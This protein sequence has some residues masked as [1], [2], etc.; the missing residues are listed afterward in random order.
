MPKNAT[1]TCQAGSPTQLTDTA[2]SAARVIGLQDFYLCATLTASPPADLDGAIMMLPFSVL[3]ADLPLVDL[4]PGVG[5]SVYLWGWPVGSDPSE[6]V[7]VS[8]SHA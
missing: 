3:A 4:F 2:V 7:D 1:V 6:I 5:A 8:V